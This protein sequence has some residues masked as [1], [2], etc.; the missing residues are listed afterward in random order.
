VAIQEVSVAAQWRVLESQTFFLCPNG[1]PG[2]E[3][4]SMMG[5]HSDLDAKV[6]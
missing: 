1:H 4:K 2:T 6:D 3:E 5:T